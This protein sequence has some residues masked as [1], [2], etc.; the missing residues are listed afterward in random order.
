MRTVLLFYKDNDATHFLPY[1]R[2]WRPAHLAGRGRGIHRAGQIGSGVQH[3]L[4]GLRFSAHFKEGADIGDPV[5]PAA[6][7]SSA[8][9]D[10]RAVAGRRKLGRKWRMK[11]IRQG[12]WG[13]AG[14][15]FFV[16][17]RRYAVTGNHEPKALT[18]VLL[19]AS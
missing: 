11:S 1:A 17:G 12:G 2:S 16:I 7:A 8:G 13:V 15:P 19:A 10:S 5:V 18:E 3:C 6:A 14:V 9:M 4:A